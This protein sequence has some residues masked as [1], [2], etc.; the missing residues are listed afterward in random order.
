[1]TRQQ[2]YELLKDFGHSASKAL[3]VAISYERGD[4]LAQQWV[5]GI[6]AA[7]AKQEEKAND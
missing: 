5:S 3:E 6:L 7:Q 4:K 2:V 1:M